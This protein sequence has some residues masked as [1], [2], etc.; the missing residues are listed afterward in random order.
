MKAKSFGITSDSVNRLNIVWKASLAKNKYASDIWNALSTDPDLPKTWRLSPDAKSRMDA[1][2]AERGYDGLQF[3]FTLRTRNEPNGPMDQN[4]IDP[5]EPDLGKGEIRIIMTGWK[6]SHPN[7]IAR[8]YVTP[9]RVLS[10]A[11][12]A[13]L[14]D[15]RYIN[16][17]HILNIGIVY[18]YNLTSN[19]IGCNVLIY[20]RLDPTQMAFEANNRDDIRMTR[21]KRV[22]ILMQRPNKGLIVSKYQNIP[23]GFTDDYIVLENSADSAL[24]GENAIVLFNIANMINASLTPG[25]PIEPLTVIPKSSTDA[26]NFKRET[27]TPIHL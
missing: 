1:L 17:K 23:P 5:R 4:G 6:G 25:K 22:D 11:Q 9:D 18:N 16:Q 26:P 3:S 7:E 27:P 20:N 8:L 2:L 10:S 19:I 15:E 12:N 21:Q 14:M 13:L 24:L